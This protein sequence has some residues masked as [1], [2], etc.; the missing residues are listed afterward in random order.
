MSGP[1]QKATKEKS[2]NTSRKRNDTS[3]KAKLPPNSL[4]PA[5]SPDASETRTQLSRL[6]AGLSSQLALP[7]KQS[8]LAAS[9]QLETRLLGGNMPSVTF[10]ANKQSGSDTPLNYAA[11][12]LKSLTKKT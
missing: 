8:G 6:A 12:A 5:V 1:E 2:A 10:E 4:P 9:L 7:A 11:S 3:F